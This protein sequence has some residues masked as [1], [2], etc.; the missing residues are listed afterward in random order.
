MKLMLD[1]LIEW[2][3]KL[4]Y[5]DTK[6]SYE[7]K[8]RIDKRVINDNKEREAEKKDK[9]RSESGNKIDSG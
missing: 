9:A 6:M 5:T 1:N 8:K 2:L 7:Q 3:L 4:M